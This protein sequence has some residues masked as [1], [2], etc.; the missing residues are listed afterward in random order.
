MGEINIDE[1]WR[2]AFSNFNDNRNRAALAEFIVA[3]ALGI[4]HSPATSWEMYDM[5]TDTG[6]KVEVKS[7]AFIQEWVQ[8]KDT[9]PTFDIKRKQGWKGDGSD[10]DGIE[11]RHADVYVFC[12]EHEKEL[13][14][15]IK[16]NPLQTDNWMFWV[17]PTPLI[18]DQLK[19]Q[20]TVR[21][22]TI[23]KVLRIKPIGFEELKGAIGAIGIVVPEA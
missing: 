9:V 3:K 7:S 2:Y 5:K 8:K 22:S 21:I 1:V 23:E 18:N 20:K 17:V 11:A 13:P 10:Y 4:S 6:I 15:S 14:E 16:P 12:L 19:E